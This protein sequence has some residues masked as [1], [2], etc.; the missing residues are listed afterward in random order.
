[1]EEKKD[2]PGKIIDD[3]LSSFST[4]SNEKKISVG[5]AAVM[6]ISVL[7]LPW[8]SFMGRS[9]TLMEGDGTIHALILAACAG[10]IIFFNFKND[11]EKAKYTSLGSIGYVFAWIFIFSD[12]GS[13]FFDFAGM[14]F[15][16]LVIS[17]GA[18]AYF[19]HKESN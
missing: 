18:S 5:G 19:A 9:I 15:Y 16:L 17:A 4:F 12:A 13:K 10:A 2:S 3:L 11:S 14:G 1:M 8:A 7:F 6:I